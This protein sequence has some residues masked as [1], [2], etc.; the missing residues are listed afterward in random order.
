MRINIGPI[1]NVELAED[2]FEGF[3]H[4]Y[5][6]KSC[7]PKYK[8]IYLIIDGRKNKLSYIKRKPK[9]IFQR[10]INKIKCIIE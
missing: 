6:H 9:S 4:K 2:C 8:R 1:K 3:Y 10:I 5:F 7:E